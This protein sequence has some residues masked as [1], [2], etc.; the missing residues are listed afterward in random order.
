MWWINFTFPKL[1]E[2]DVNKKESKKAETYS[3]NL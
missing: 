1:S 2:I 3:E